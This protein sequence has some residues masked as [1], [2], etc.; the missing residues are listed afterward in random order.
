MGPCARTGARWR[1]QVVGL[2]Q[3]GARPVGRLALLLRSHREAAGLTQRQLAA[4]AGISAGA[5]EDLEQGRTRRPRPESL[6]RLAAALGLTG[7]QRGELAAAGRHHPDP[8]G[9]A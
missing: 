7:E 4:R 6:N 5:L 9:L 8:G 2:A 1:K 3:R